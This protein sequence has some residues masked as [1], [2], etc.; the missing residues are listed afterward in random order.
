MAHIRLRTPPSGE[1]DHCYGE[2]FHAWCI[3]QAAALKTKNWQDLDFDHLAEEVESLGKSERRE[4]SS[5]LGVLLMHLLKYAMQPEAHSNSWRASILEQRQKISQSLRDNPSLR[6]YPSQ[7]LDTCYQDAADLASEETGIAQS[8]F[9]EKCPF[10]I[11]QILDRTFLP[12]A[13]NS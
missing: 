2:D 10:T 13:N 1:T 12:T 4:I 8:G 6:S 7:I 3:S 5:R 9:P 11:E